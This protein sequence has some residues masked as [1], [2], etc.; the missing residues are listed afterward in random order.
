MPAPQTKQARTELRLCFANGSVFPF[1]SRE[2]VACIR[3]RG[4][5]AGLA[6]MSLVLAVG[7][8][9]QVLGHVPFWARLMLNAF[10]VAVFL[11]VFPAILSEVEAFARRRGWQRVPEPM[12]TLPAALLI[13]LASEALAVF[14]VGELV[15]TQRELTIRV[16]IGLVYWETVVNIL[17][18]YYAP[19][20][21]HLALEAGDPP[22]GPARPLQVRLGGLD[23]DPSEVLHVESDDHFL[24]LH[25][26][27]GRHRVGAR[28]RDAETAL[29]EHGIAVHRSHWLALRELGPVRRAG[30]SYLMRTA[31]GQDVPVARDRRK[32]VA[33]ALAG[34]SGSC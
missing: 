5:V 24:I 14:L 30:R 1:S 3:S 31:S 29:S 13:T 6:F 33:A 7:S 28:F 34:V 27:T 8:G 22:T 4:V 18:L 12:A 21:N 2:L 25:T 11:I 16:I 32:A 9:D 15:L 20:I 10:A 17:M 26:K 23:I 19:T